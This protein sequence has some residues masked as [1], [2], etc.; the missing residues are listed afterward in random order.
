MR[1]PSAS[2]AA[3]C[4]GLCLLLG[5]DRAGAIPAFAR[6]YGES[7][8][9]CHVAIPQLNAFGKAFRNNGYRFPRETEDLLQQA[10][11]PLG[12]EPQKE[13]WPADAVW[14]GAIPASVPLA[15]RVEGDYVVGAD[16][17]VSSDFRWPHEV[18]LLSAGTLGSSVSYFLELIPFRDGAFGGVHRAFVQFDRLLRGSRLLNLRVGQVEPEAVPF[19]RNRRATMTDYLTTSFKNGANPFSFG[20]DQRGVEAWGIRDGRAGGGLL[21]AVGV[22]NGNGA[23]GKGAAGTLDDNAAKDVYG[24]LHYK[25]GGLSL[26]GERGAPPQGGPWVDEAAGLGAFAY[27]GWGTLG[28]FYRYGFDLAWSRGDLTLFGL[29]E[30]GSDRFDGGGEP[31]FRAWFAEADY[32]FAP[33]VLGALRYERADADAGADPERLVS[34][35]SLSLRPN[36]VLRLEALSVLHGGDRSQGKARLDVAF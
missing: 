1:R 14:P 2:P 11:L 30:T 13:L 3:A 7:C 28:T 4:L 6:L 31:A 12:G 29:W 25:L 22:V 36:L 26:T 10:P 9:T 27:R 18:Y 8:T 33:W 21:W 15:V 35:V 16:E 17:E 34:H 32:V 23:G 20:D 24:R 19:S 5:A